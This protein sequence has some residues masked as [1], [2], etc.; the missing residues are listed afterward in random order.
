MYNRPNTYRYVW[1]RQLA[2][3]S[4]PFPK[5]YKKVILIDSENMRFNQVNVNLFPHAYFIFY[6]S[7]NGNCIPTVTKYNKYQNCRVVMTPVVGKDACDVQK[8]PHIS[9]T[10]WRLQNF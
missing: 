4:L 8:V 3:F 9:A 6:I 5:T 1:T 10:Q 2:T 7:R